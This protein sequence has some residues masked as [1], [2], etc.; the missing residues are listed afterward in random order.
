VNRR[1]FLTGSI[2]LS[3]TPVVAEAQRAEKVAFLCPDSCSNLPN[4]IDEHDRAFL[5]ALESAGYVLGRNTSIDMSGAGVGYDRLT[6]ASRRLVE[7]NTDVIV[8]F[9]NAATRAARQAT[10]KTPIVMVNVADAVDDGFVESLSRP[11]TNVTGLSVPLGQVAAKSIELLKELNPKIGRVAVVWDATFNVEQRVARLERAVGS[12]GVEIA[13]VRVATVHD[14]EKTFA[15]MGQRRPEAL[16]ILEQLARPIRGEIALFALRQRLATAGS[17]RSFVRGGGLLAY[18]PDIVKQLERAGVYAGR[19]LR[20]KKPSELP[21]EE[22]SRFE[23]VLNK[24]TATT[25]G[26]TIPPSLLLRADQ[27]IE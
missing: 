21:V 22:P 25:L 23:L 26:L 24:A 3:A 18:S 2:A 7:R 10:K 20:G 19:L 27:V 15:V 14:L 12:L 6:G 1:A 16:L 4:T 5:A 13:P 11:G 9:G 17:D 8:A